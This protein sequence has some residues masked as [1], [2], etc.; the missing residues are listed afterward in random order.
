M[1]EN[2]HWLIEDVTIDNVDQIF[3]YNF[4]NGLWQTGQPAT[5]ITFKN[6]TA[7]NV[8]KAFNMI[9]DSARSLK[10]T[11]RNA[12]ISERIDSDFTE[13][14]F[15]GKMQNVPAFFNTTLFDLLELH[16]VTIKTN[17][18]HPAIMAKNGNKVV[19]D[20][21]RF[22]PSDNQTPLILENIKE[23]EKP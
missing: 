4:K 11:I 19:M 16:H 23:T 12:S 20:N 22:I 18:K 8:K 1:I 21:V 13:F 10:L 2:G 9:G 17:G 6:L 15:E 5:E 7:T 3:N 14:N